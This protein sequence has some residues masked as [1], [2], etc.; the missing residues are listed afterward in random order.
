[1]KFLLFIIVQV[2]PLMVILYFAVRFKK[3]TENAGWIVEVDSEC[4]CWT[5]QNFEHRSFRWT[6]E[7]VSGFAHGAGELTVIQNGFDYAFF[8]GSLVN[9]KAEG[10]GQILWLDGD[11]FEGH[12]RKGS[13]E[14]FGRMYNDDGD[15]YEGTFKNGQR[16]GMGTYWYEPGNRLLKYVGSWEA[17]LKHGAGTLFFRDG[18]QISRSYESGKLISTRE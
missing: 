5:S 1:M 6:G 14:G 3:P 15:Y 11:R 2:F 7:C 18:T 16:W 17:G 10:A 13:P 8:S 9:G 4:K 12:F